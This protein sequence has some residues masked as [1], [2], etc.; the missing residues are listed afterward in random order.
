MSAEE[1]KVIRP[2]ANFPLCIWGDLFLA[3]DEQEEQDRITEHAVQELKH[4][5]RKE[6]LSK[7]NVPDEHLNLLKFIDA[8][9]R[10]GIAYYFEEEINKA[11]QHVYDAYGDNW[12]GG[13]ISLWFRLM[14]QQGFFVSCDIM[15]NYK[16]KDGNFTENLTNDVE[17]VLSLYEATFLRV[18]GEVILDDA[19][20]FTRAC[21]ADMAKARHL[22]DNIYSTHVIQRALKQP[23][24][25]RL[26]RLDAI[27]YIPFYQQQP[28]HNVSLLKL[29]K[30]GFDLLQSL[31]KKELSQL[32]KW[33][34]ALDV[35]NNF[36]Y[37]RNRLV[38]C[39]FWAQGVYFEPEYSKSRFFLAKILA[40]GTVLDDTYDAY[41]TYEEL[42]IFT[43]AIQRWSLMC[44][45]DLPEYMK[46]LYQMIFDVHKEMEEFM[47]SYGKEHHLNYMKESMKEYVGSYMTEAKWRK[48]EYIP[49]PE[50]HTSVALISCGYKFLLISSFVGMGDLVTD[51]SFK[52]ALSFPP[53]VKA[54]C[55][56]CR[57]QD[58]VVTY[59]E[60]HEREHVSSGI[61]CY[62]KEFDVSKEHVINLFLE[63]VETAWTKMNQESL[64][65][66]DVPMP[67][68][69]RVI[70]FAR[71]I[72]VLYK[73]EDNFTHVREEQQN[74]IKSLLIHS[75]GK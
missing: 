19:L 53:L 64:I 46:L 59:K 60:E 47:R 50:E 40:I 55:T 70:N 23:I 33:W 73:Y 54:S 18:P 3:Y 36:P 11:L 17:E 9:Q 30:L 57:F 44:L 38:E 16:D 62:L 2:T 26:P 22:V 10:L 14:R 71:V 65:C 66:K 28:S 8:I 72:E 24:R 39:Y 37:A 51:D 49:S 68:V 20:I 13:C 35:P 6:I 1:E 42:V 67:L 43:E 74:H 31:H 4:E 61:D 25:K 45:D 58:D 34:K 27:Q 75:M 29:A 7:L 5:V 52:W 32:S 48:D 69:M 63:K 15:K 21:L 12:N 56:V 41:G